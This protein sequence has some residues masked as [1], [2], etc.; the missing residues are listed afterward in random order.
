[1]VIFSAEPRVILR[2]RRLPDGI[3]KRAVTSQLW[4]DKEEG[5]EEKKKEKKYQWS[6]REQQVFTKWKRVS[7]ERGC[8]TV[9][10][11]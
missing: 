3:D 5:G 9:S 10:S 1:M 7:T 8:S 2:S 4:A 6:W 11:Y